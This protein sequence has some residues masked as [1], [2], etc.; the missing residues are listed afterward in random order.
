MQVEDLTR[1]LDELR[2][3]RISGGGRGGEYNNNSPAFVELD[4]LRK[5]IMVAASLRH[6]LINLSRLLFG[7]FLRPVVL[8]DCVCV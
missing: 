3:G 8:D 7:A 4:K 1:Q 2:N 6:S 5:D